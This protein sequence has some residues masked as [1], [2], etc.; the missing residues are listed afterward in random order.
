MRPGIRPAPGKFALWSPHRESREVIAFRALLDVRSEPWH[1]VE[2]ADDAQWIVVEARRGVSRDWTRRVQ[3]GTQVGIALAPRW[4]DVPDPAWRYLPLPL[5]PSS[6][7]R[8]IETQLSFPS[9]RASDSATAPARWEGQQ[10]KLS[11]WPNLARYGEASMSL[12][13]ACGQMLRGPIRYENLRVPER[14]LPALQQLLHDAFAQ[15]RLH[16]QMDTDGGSASI[17]P[18][19]AGWGLLQR[20]ARRMGLGGST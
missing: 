9:D 5:H 10:L 12:T 18:V 6:A 7:I 19:G 2:H 8:W 17:E 4:S 16:T 11:S 1:W 14:D 20:I 15:G 13:I 3:S